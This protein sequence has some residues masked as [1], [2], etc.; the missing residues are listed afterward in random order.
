MTPADFMLPGH[1]RT[2]PPPL[3]G[4]VT[5]RPRRVVASV[6]TEQVTVR[7]QALEDDDLH[8]PV[9][10]MRVNAADQQEVAAQMNVAVARIPFIVR[11]QSVVAPLFGQHCCEVWAMSKPPPC[12]P[13]VHA[14]AVI[15]SDG[16]V[17]RGAVVSGCSASRFRGKRRRPCACLGMGA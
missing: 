5:F 15:A 11:D 7:A 8:I 17:E 9:V 13:P 6:S 12:S 16:A 3:V 14:V 2:E 1:G 10:R 4:G